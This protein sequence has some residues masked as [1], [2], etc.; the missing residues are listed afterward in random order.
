MLD[1]GPIRSLPGGTK[2]GLAGRSS[3]ELVNPV[4]PRSLS[5]VC[6][7]VKTHFQGGHSRR[8]LRRMSRVEYIIALRLALS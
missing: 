3:R 4:M 2:K 8:R 1:P 7:L 5:N 6:S